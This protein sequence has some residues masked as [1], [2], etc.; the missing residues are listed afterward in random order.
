MPLSLSPP[1][2]I[3]FPIG[4]S[5]YMIPVS[6]EVASAQLSRLPETATGRGQLR[7]LL[8]FSPTKTRSLNSGLLL[9]KNGTIESQMIITVVNETCQIFF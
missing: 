6:P 5:D 1:I 2:S 3:A 7:S 9:E 4:T 8:V